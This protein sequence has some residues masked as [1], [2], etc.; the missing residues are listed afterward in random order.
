MSECRFS[1]RT[2]I[3]AVEVM[4]SEIK[5]HAALTRCLLTWGA[6]LS[7][8]CDPG[9]LAERFNHLIKFFHEHPDYGLDDGS[10]LGD[11]LVEKAVSL[12]PPPKRGIP[13]RP[14]SDPRPPSPRVAAFLRRLDIDG[15]AVTDGVLRRA[16]PQTLKLPEA[17]DEI[18]RLLTKHGFMVAK[19]HL[20]QAFIAHTDGL[21]AS[22]NAQIRNFLDGLLD[23]I[24]ER[25][26][27]SAAAMSSGQPRRTKLAA[28][29]FLSR[30]LNEWDD[31][32]LGFLN[33]L[34]KRLHSQG[35]H[36]GLSDQDDSTF[37]LHT[38]LLTARLLLVRF[39]TWGVP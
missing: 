14:A 5:S 33:G 25:I 21:W 13:W 35:P 39:D 19:G 28:R 15:F 30:P 34:V 18:V 27:P 8:R 29:G 1:R 2:I 10:L 9:S 26:D 31:S 37:R 36:P 11:A 7:T 12:L 22:A 38:V 6:E 4:E 24:A 23:E 3:S 17:N 20:D 16:L 32:G